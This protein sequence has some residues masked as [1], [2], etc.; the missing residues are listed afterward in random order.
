MEDLGKKSIKKKD[1]VGETLLELLG[2]WWWVVVES[3]RGEHLT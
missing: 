2:H 3:S 1:G